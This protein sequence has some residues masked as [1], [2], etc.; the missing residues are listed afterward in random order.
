MRV[1]AVR[2]VLCEVNNF[3]PQPAPLHGGHGTTS[4]SGANSTGGAFPTDTALSVDDAKI[5]KRTRYHQA[6]TRA[7]LHAEPFVMRDYSCVHTKAL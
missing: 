1:V 3:L 2:K 7:F 4:V 6:R 5:C